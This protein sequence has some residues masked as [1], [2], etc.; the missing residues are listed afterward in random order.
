MPA[1]YK[2]YD[3]VLMREPDDTDRRAQQRR[4]V[5]DGVAGAVAAKGWSA[6]TIADIASAARASRSTVYAHF[7]DKDEALLALHHEVSARLV[8]VVLRA[9]REAGPETP[10]R[11]RLEATMEAYL[12]AMA[13][14]S[15]GERASLLEVASVG[16]DARRAR[17]EGLDR[18]AAVVARTSVD[19]AA[20][21][22][23]AEPLSPALALAAVAAVNELVQRAADDGPD[24]IRALA[25]VAADVFE[26]L[27][28]RPAATAARG[29]ERA[30]GAPASPTQS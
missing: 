25:P 7:P 5:L 17:R 23:D 9:H 6:T 4:Q 26:R 21:A 30:A 15:A 24:A 1:E 29:A 27:M 13:A 3:F 28:R 8:D 20:S 2:W 22:P 14:A 10:W 11:A 12:D 19:L 18:F 16:P